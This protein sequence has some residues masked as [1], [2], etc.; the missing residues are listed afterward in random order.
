MVS[1]IR[2]YRQS[3]EETLAKDLAE[4]QEGN[5]EN[6]RMIEMLEKKIQQQE[7][8]IKELEIVQQRFQDWGNGRKDDQVDEEKYFEIFNNDLV[9]EQMRYGIM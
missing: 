8:R 5:T 2:K 3:T 9:L 6:K 1:E 7:E 4:Q